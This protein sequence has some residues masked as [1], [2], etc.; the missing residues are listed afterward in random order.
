MQCCEQKDADCNVLW[1]GVQTTTSTH[2]QQLD[3]RQGRTLQQQREEV[4]VV[5]TAAALQE[6]VL[7]GKPHIEI[8]EHLDLTALELLDFTL[9]RDLEPTSQSY[10]L[11]IVPSTVKSIRV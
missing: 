1:D 8:Q 9:L 10:L 5:T 7:A 11:G 4:T 3:E 2:K 6:S